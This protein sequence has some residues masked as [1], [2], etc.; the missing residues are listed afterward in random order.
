M[1]DD[2]KRARHA[3][4]T[5][6]APLKVRGMNAL[7]FWREIYRRFDPEG[8]PQ[9]G[10]IA[11]RAYS[12]VDDI[13]DDIGLRFGEQ[14][15][16]VFGTIGTGKSTELRRLAAKR[17]AEDFTL[18]LDIYRF[19]EE[20]LRDAPAMEHIAPW[21]IVQLIGLAIYRAGAEKLVLKWRDAETSALEGA[22]RALAPG[23][24]ASTT[25]LDLMKLAQG[26]TTLVGLP[27]LSV[28]G[29]VLE[30]LGG[31]TE[32]APWKLRI[33]RRAERS[34]DDQ[35]GRVRS[36][37][38]AV[39][40]LI[41]RIQHE[42]LP[43]TLVVDGLDRM[44][45]VDATR[46]MFLDS[47]LLGE[48]ACVTLV[49][50]PLA[51]H[52]EGMAA[53]VRGFKPKV[54]ANV[55]VFER[56]SGS[57]VLMAT[58]AGR[59]FFREL[60]TRRLQGVCAVEALLSDG[61]LDAF[62]VASGGRV[63]DFMHLMQNLARAGGRARTRAVSDTMVATAID[64]RRRD[65]ELGLDA[66]HLAVLREVMANPMQLPAAERTEELIRNQWLLPYPNESL[67]WYPHPLLTRKQLPPG[68]TS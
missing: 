63:R 4:L 64:E 22:I 36:L 45:S 53:S 8:P 31:A 51:V 12:P 32:D 57:A 19:M 13:A 40:L 3:C 1:F 25:R 7:D 66:G 52:H 68:A 17:A 47:R 23:E 49:T 27:G 59:T 55:P 30:A 46:R 24:D 15:F 9:D 11:P 41:G 61:Q 34:L 48:L 10:W 5:L 60:L 6:R 35:D 16:M 39:N 56:P 21:E 43:I 65:L 50:A 37:L 29:Q 20:R 42:H 44:S 62:A 2:G 28:A 14:K 26:V 67:W 38:S 58:E 54:L 33:G 18:V